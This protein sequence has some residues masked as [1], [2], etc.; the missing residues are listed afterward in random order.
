MKTLTLLLIV[1]LLFS[2]NTISQTDQLNRSLNQNIYHEKELFEFSQN[3]N[4]NFREILDLWRLDSM[5]T[6]N[7]Q[8][9]DSFDFRKSIITYDDLT[10]RV[11]V[12]GIERSVTGEWQY[13]S[14]NSTFYNENNLQIKY[15][16]Y[17]WEHQ[18]WRVERRI[19]YTYNYDNQMSFQYHYHWDTIEGKWLNQF[20]LEYGYNEHGDNNLFIY[21]TT[22]N[23]TNDWLYLEK[24]ETTYSYDGLEEEKITQQWDTYINQWENHERITYSYEDDIRS[25]Y[26]DYWID[27]EWKHFAKSDG[28]RIDPLTEI[29]NGYTYR[30]DSIWIHDYEAEIRYDEAGNNIFQ[31]SYRFLEADSL[32]IGA[33]KFDRFYNET[34]QYVGTTY[35]KWIYVNNNWVYNNKSNN[36]YNDENIR[37]YYCTYSWYED[38]WLKETS[39]TSFFTNI[40]TINESEN[41]NIPIKVHPNP[42][43]NQI[44]IDLEN[45]DNK[46]VI[47]SIYSMSGKI[48][49]NGILKS[50]STINIDMLDKGYYLIKIDIG[51]KIY[52]AKFLKL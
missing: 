44:T 7:V 5:V 38:H 51:S 8:P 24:K 6:Y 33:V 34:G 35:Y 17:V 46:K 28:Y 11:D 22:D 3:I 9:L 1:S 42:C 36:G 19:D 30:F 39:I 27:N 26:R 37:F 21:Y 40:S 20:K 15:L 29:H 50:N 47:Y 43:T 31:E 2:I 48:V 23:I 52:S 32:W 25:H 16:R 45:T 41:H 14:K 12:T 4:S 13:S 18:D 49:K 10:N